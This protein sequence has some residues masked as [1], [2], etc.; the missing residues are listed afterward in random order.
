MKKS[1]TAQR[2]FS[3]ENEF[4]IL[5]TLSVFIPENAQRIFNTYLVQVD[6]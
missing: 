5:R 3:T 1:V 2:I 6:Q 4:F